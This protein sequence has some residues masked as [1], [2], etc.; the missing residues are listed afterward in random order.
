[1]ANPEQA[2]TL[3]QK[4]IEI[5]DE[6]RQQLSLQLFNYFSKLEQAHENLAKLDISFAKALQAIKMGLVRPE[7]A[8]TTTSY[9]HIFNPWVKDILALKQK[10]FQPVDITLDSEPCLITGANM[11]GKTV[12]LKTIALAQYLFQFGFYIPASQASIVPVDAVFFSLEDEQSELSGLS[13]F[14]AEM[15]NINEIFRSVHSGKKILALIDEPARTTNPEEGRA[16]VNAI[17]TMLAKSGIRSLVTSHYSNLN[18]TCRKLRVKGLQFSSAGVKLTFQDINNYMDY[19]LLEQD[20]D[21][22]PLDALRIATML[23][24]DKELIEQATLF[25]KQNK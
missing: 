14:A 23:G 8:S 25:L 19:S 21:D 15:L 18:V 6:I 4:C 22:V 10:E 1:L 13:S 11:G 5:E 17:V 24:V 2:E 7:V 3:R 12:L 9:T 16:L 20:T